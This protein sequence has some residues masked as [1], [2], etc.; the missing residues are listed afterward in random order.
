MNEQYNGR[1]G[2]GYQPCQ[3]SPN[4]RLLPPPRKP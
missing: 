1:Y 4:Q 2:W 3:K